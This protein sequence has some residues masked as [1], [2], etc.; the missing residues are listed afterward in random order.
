MT[1]F[2]HQE[3]ARDFLKT[4]ATA[5]LADEPGLGKT[6]SAI[7][8]ADAL[9]LK[10]VLVVCPAIAQAHWKDHIVRYGQM[11]SRYFKVISYDKLS[12]WKAD[13]LKPLVEIPWDLLI[14]DEGHYLKS[15]GAKRTQRVYGPKCDGVNGLVAHAKQTWV[16]TGTPAP[17][18]AGELW[19]H[20][21]ALFG[22]PAHE[23]Q[24][25]GKFCITRQL[26]NIRQPIVTGSKNMNLL[27][28]MLAKHM[29]RRKTDE[30]LTLPPLRFTTE[31]LPIENAPAAAQE[32]LRQLPQ[33]EDQ[34]AEEHMATVRRN[35]GLAK[36]PL[37]VD[38]VNNVL[39]GNHRKMLIFAWHQ[40]VIRQLQEQLAV[41]NPV[42][43]YGGTPP[44]ARSHAITSFQEHPEI[45][46]FI[47]QIRACGTAITL[48]A[49]QDVVFAESDWTP[50]N[51]FQAAK[52][53]H[54]IGQTQSVLAR[55][56]SVSNTFEVNLH[57]NLARKE[58]E[59][60]A[61]IEKEKPN[62]HAHFPG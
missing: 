26:P 57:R 42:T 37:V 29:L 62:D 6:V 38:Y 50:E 4:R 41:F 21:R 14:L 59:I 35:L 11:K 23:R 46:I 60:A 32:V 24:W 27:Q 9:H 53:A 12:R 22:C 17:N 5:L 28:P 2:P 61:M 13:Q 39:E 30:V 52:R 7:T 34:D 58:R 15:S 54:R 43:I 55:H 48:T 45:R 1:L 20:F 56:L 49:A 51:N 3:V 8:A 18:H 44:T 40:E 33:D 16:L 25:Q 31:L 47:G 36:V 19:T 10:R